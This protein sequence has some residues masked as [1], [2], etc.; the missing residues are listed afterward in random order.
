MSKRPLLQL[1]AADEI[2]EQGRAAARL[3]NRAAHVKRVATYF[4][5]LSEGLTM[6]ARGPG[7]YQP[8]RSG[9]GTGAAVARL[10]ARAAAAR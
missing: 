7:L 3:Y 2:G 8:D 5:G 9:A 4:F 10:G 1:R 6:R